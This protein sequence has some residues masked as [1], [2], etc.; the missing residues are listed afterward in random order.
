VKSLLLG[1]SDHNHDISGYPLLHSV[2]Q[3]DIVDG[4][5]YWQHPRYITDPVT[6]RNTGFEITNT[7]MVND[8]LHSNVVGLSRSAILGKPYTVSEVNHPAPSEYASE[9]IP[10]LAAYA[11]LQD[12]DGIFWY[13]FEHRQPSDWQAKQPSH[14]EFRTDPVK[15]TELAAGAIMFQRADV[16]KALET[17]TRSYSI[18]QIY[19]SLR[20]PRA[21]RPYFTPGFPLALP[22]VHG[23]RIASLNGPP[24]G[25]FTAI[26][27]G[28][29]IS[30]TKELAWQ[31]GLV[32]VDSERSQA[33]VGNV[34]GHAITHL[35]ANVQNRFCTIMLTSLDGAPLR[36]AR[37]MLLTTGSRAGNTGMK[38]NEKRTSLTD[39][40]TAPTVI[41]PVTGTITLRSLDGTASLTVAALDGAGRPIGKVK[42]TKTGDG[43]DIAVGDPVTPWYLITVK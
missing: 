17:V 34:S 10:I 12:W 6:G 32:T 31:E 8:P 4:H 41:E 18:T 15:M 27:P 9:G 16:R 37:R 20:L 1:T 3:L 42:V 28:P 26:P 5:I 19:D 22:L 7:P 35:S 30:D 38:W 13:T 11:A 24:T 33:L 2:S 23:S 43:W 40:G 25:A 36:S 29:V 39:W 21:E 14:F